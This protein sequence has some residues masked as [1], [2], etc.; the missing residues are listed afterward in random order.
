MK[1]DLVIKNAK[2]YYDGKLFDGGVAVSDGKI[3][4]V[5][6]N[7]FLP[8]AADSIDARGMAV[9]PGVI[10][11]HVHVRD[12]GHRER[13]TF[14]SETRAAAA[15]GVTSFLEHPISSPPPYSP[16]ILRTRIRVAQPQSIVDYAFFGAAG[17]EYTDEIEN[18]SK[19]GIVAFKTFLHEAP[20]G[21]DDEFRGLT[22]ANDGEIMDGFRAVARTGLILTIHAENNDMIQRLIRQFRT[23]G[24]TGFEYHAK[25]RP[26]I[27]EIATVEKLIR[28]AREYGTRI[29][30]AHV[31]TPEAMELIKCAKAQGQDIYLET[32]PHYLFLTEDVIKQLGP[33][34]KGNPPLRSRQDMKALWQ[35][36]NDGSV[37]FIGSDHGPFLVSEKESGL[38]DI[39]K[40]AAGPAAIELTLPL[41]LTAVRDG[42]ITLKRMVELLSENAARIFG[43]APDKGSLRVGSDADIVVADIDNEFTVDNKELLTQSRDTTPMYNGFRLIGRPV[44]TVVRGRV[45]MRDRKVDDSAQG[46]GKWLKPD[47]SEKSRW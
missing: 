42:K 24:K 27:T 30:I 38:K 15:G 20:E 6:S 44:H 34:A 4:A 2:V 26:P 31:S 17:A 9:L 37:D 43:L 13:G 45:V 21:R 47:W 8:E 5:G 12:P 36:V 41:M 14:A 35:Y 3:S 23:E 11:T 16:E 33:F 28:F 29:S 39:F 32:C 10:D 18:V 19:E 46:W 7:A 22:M 25:S 40:A 1:A